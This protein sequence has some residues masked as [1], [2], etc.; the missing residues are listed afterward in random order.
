MPMFLCMQ[1]SFFF[2]C[3][4][5]GSDSTTITLTFILYRL[6]A[7]QKY[8][9]RLSNDIHARF[10]SPEEMTSSALEFPFLE[11]VIIEGLLFSSRSNLSPQTPSCNTGKS[12]MRSPQRRNDDSW[13]IY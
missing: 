11:A 13:A 5:A 9:N 12:S 2:H 3:S 7:N 4:V 6:V 8:W 10:H 1:L